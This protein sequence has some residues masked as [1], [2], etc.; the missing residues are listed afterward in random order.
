MNYRDEEAYHPYWEYNMT[1]IDD[2][3]FVLL[4]RKVPQYLK[5]LNSFLE[6]MTYDNNYQK[7]PIISLLF[8]GAFYVWIVLWF[9]AWC[10][11]NNKYNYL[12]AASLPFLYWLTLFLGPVVL[13][14]YLYPII[15]STPVFICI[16]FVEK[17]E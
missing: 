7:I 6:K 12:L 4:N 13:Y 11:I 16:M 10:I 5:S 8:S 3:R 17:K 2:D 1:Q 15:I 14:R 9:I